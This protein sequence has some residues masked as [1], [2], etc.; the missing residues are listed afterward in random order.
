M[1]TQDR[2][3]AAIL[4]TDIV[5]YTGMMQKDELKAVRVI[6]HYH[7]ILEKTVAAHR[8]EILND[9]GGGSLCTFSSVLEA[10]NRAIELQRNLQLEPVVPL[11]VGL[12]VGEIFFENGK[13]LG[14]HLGE[15][16]FH[17]PF[18]AITIR[19]R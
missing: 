19:R 12:H 7:E 15:C 3:L 10:L 9:Y 2:H 8:G 18:I 11:R 4:F 5:G 6:K 1:F 17:Y 14:E 13:V 16:K